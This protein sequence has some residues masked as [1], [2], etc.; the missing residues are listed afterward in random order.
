MLPVWGKGYPFRNPFADASGHHFVSGC[1]DLPENEINS[2]RMTREG[3]KRTKPSC[4]IDMFPIRGNGYGTGVLVQTNPAYERDIQGD[5][6][7]NR[8]VGSVDHG[9]VGHQI[10]SAAKG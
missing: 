2:F 5:R 7:H 8:A 9:N 3:G 10:R 1:I 6:G 4:Y